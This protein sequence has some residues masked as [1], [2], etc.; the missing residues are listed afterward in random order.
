MN[1]EPI[2]V[3]GLSCIF[4][5]AKTKESFWTRIRDKELQTKEISKERLGLDPHFL[6]G[7]KGTVD[8]TYS[9][10]CAYIDYDVDL[11]TFE[12]KIP[13][14]SQLDPYFHWCLHVVNEAL[15]DANMHQSP[16]LKE[17]GLILGNLTFATEK[18]EEASEDQLLSLVTNTHSDYKGS[19]SNIDARNFHQSAL[20]AQICSDYFGLGIQSYALDAAC[21]SSLYVIHLACEQIWTKQAKQM[22]ALGVNRSEM[23]ALQVGFSQLGAYSANNQCRPFDQNADGLVVG[24]GGGALILKPLSQ[25]LADGD[26]IHCVIRGSGLSCDGKDGGLL[27]PS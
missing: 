12:K 9:K 25:A 1:R 2:A 10:H 3:V 14:L 16:Q 17:T 4:A 5:G 8:K 11:S 21:A 18:A 23:V 13:N 15:S 22:I 26:N 24:E 27:A 7:K 20:P 6:I 19:N